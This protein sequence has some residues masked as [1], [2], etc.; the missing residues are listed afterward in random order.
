MNLRL[1]T[2]LPEFEVRQPG[3]EGR[4]PRSKGVRYSLS[5]V[6]SQVGPSGIVHLY[7]AGNGRHI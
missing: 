5:A 2:V 6:A 7:R 4:R 3:P 1:V